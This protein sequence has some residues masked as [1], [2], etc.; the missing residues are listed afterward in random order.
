MTTAEKNSLA[1]F[2]DLAA[3]VTGSGYRLRDD[4]MP[5]MEEIA[6][7]AAEYAPEM[8]SEAAS[9]GASADSLETVAA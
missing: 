7:P 4:P 3:A 6:E 8:A 1:R 2:L 9:G 5:V